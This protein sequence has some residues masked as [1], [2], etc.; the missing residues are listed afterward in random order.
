MNVKQLGVLGKK[1]SSDGQKALK[2]WNAGQPVD[3][4]WDL[5]DGLEF[6]KL[7]AEARRKA[8]AMGPDEKIAMPERMA[9]VHASALFRDASYAA[10]GRKFMLGLALETRLRALYDGARLY[11]NTGGDEN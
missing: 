10:A 1:R 6:E 9:A 11:V 2:Q 8:K 4:V 3:S 7:K 5:D